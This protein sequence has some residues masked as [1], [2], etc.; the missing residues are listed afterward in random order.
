[1]LS[2]SSFSFRLFSLFSSPSESPSRLLNKE[3]RRDAG[4]SN[5]RRRVTAAGMLNGVGT[6]S[7]ILVEH[8]AVETDAAFP[9]DGR[10]VGVDRDL[11]EFTHVAPQLE[12][13]DLKQVA[14]EHAAL[15][16]VF[17][18]QPELVVFLRLACRYSMHLVPL[19][20]CFHSQLSAPPVWYSITRVSKKLRSFF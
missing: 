12:R 8:V 20:F 5:R 6:R 1:M 19:L 18:A 9:G 16:S 11:L 4:L 17:E 3:A 15:E 13:A 7:E 10:G 14:E 2:S